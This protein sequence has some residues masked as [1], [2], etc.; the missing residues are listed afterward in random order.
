MSIWALANN[1][2]RHSKSCS[3]QKK[4]R[5]KNSNL[6]TMTSSKRSLIVNDFV[7]NAMSKQN[8]WFIIQSD[9]TAAHNIVHKSFFLLR[10][11]QKI[12][13]DWLGVW[14]TSIYMS[15]KWKDGT[16]HQEGTN[17]LQ[18][19]EPLHVWVFPLSFSVSKKKWYSIFWRRP[20]E[21]LSLSSTHPPLTLF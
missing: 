16:Q 7:N 13:I 19:I 1:K 3:R 10:P 15:E 18:P 21:K 20:W 6:P 4:I 8:L 12:Q 2:N 11:W 9:A 14:R 5:T 17:A